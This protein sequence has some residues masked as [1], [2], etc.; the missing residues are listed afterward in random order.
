[1][2]GEDGDIGWLRGGCELV[3]RGLGFYWQ[4]RPSSKGLLILSDGGD[5]TFKGGFA[6]ETRH[7]LSREM[8]ANVGVILGQTVT[9]CLTFVKKKL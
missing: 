4:C 1:M 7:F 3:V 8:S 6:R 5:P 9:G 2:D